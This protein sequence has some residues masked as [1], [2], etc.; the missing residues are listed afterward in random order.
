V[1]WH[2]GSRGEVRRL[3]AKP[4]VPVVGGMEE[5]E[6]LGRE[7]ARRAPVVL[8]VGA[9]AALR[10][11]SAL[12]RV[13]NERCSNTTAH[14]RCATHLRKKGHPSGHVPRR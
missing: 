14:Y 7:L 4:E 5:G 2:G 11:I 8:V 10:I 13:E 3:R 12:S 6:D 1:G 9:S